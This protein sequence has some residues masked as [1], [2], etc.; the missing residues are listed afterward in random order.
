MNDPLSRPTRNDVA[1]KAGVSSATVSRVYN[2]PDSVSPE[3]A[4]KVLSAA[5]TL[6]Y[7]PNRQASSLRRR[8]SGTITLAAFRKKDR[9]Y[10]WGNQPLLKWMYADVIRSV[11]DEVSQSMFHLQIQTIET[12]GDLESL[13]QS[14]GIIGYDVDTEH[15]AQALSALKKPYIICHHTEDLGSHPAVRTDNLEGGRIQARW[16]QGRGV[17]T[18]LYITG[19][20]DEVP[21]DRKRMEGFIEVYGRKNLLLIDDLSGLEEAR[22]RAA[23]I[24]KFIVKNKIDGIGFVNDMTLLGIMTGDKEVPIPEDIAMAGYDNLPVLPLFNENPA[25]VDLRLNRIYRRAVTKLI[26]DI[27]GGGSTDIQENNN[28]TEI[29]LPVLKAPL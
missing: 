29:I 27:T 19:R 8:G 1:E 22:A 20:I 10:Y 26:A 2:N 5:E 14:D 21:A 23:E 3:K 28:K 12:E 16:L 17:Q 6:G 13:K 7:E 4:E 11:M 15:E 25:T 24:R 9:P 18:P